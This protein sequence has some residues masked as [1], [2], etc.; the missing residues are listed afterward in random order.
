MQHPVSE[1]EIPMGLGMALARNPEAMQR[2]GTLT[3]E[4]QRQI[5]EQTHNIG[6]KQEMRAFVEQLAAGRKSAGN[7]QWVSTG[8]PEQ[9]DQRVRRD[10]PGGN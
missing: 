5:I 9:P 1:N 6:S 4:Q 7:N 10:G 3:G 8:I 2:F